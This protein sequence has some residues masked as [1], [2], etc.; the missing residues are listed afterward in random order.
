MACG[1]STAEGGGFE[2]SPL[3]RIAKHKIG[4]DIANQLDDLRTEL[5]V[6]GTFAHEFS[7]MMSEWN[8]VDSMFIEQRKDYDTVTTTRIIPKTRNKGK[9]KIIWQVM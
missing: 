4:N 6:V 3:G 1:P 7:F 2:S 9:I 5:S 8:L